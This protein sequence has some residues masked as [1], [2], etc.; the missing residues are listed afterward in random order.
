MTTDRAY[1]L[2]CFDLELCLK[3]W[4]SKQI[5]RYKL[6]EAAYRRAVEIRDTYFPDKQQNNTNEQH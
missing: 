1:E 2:A 4:D 6:A 3:I 5:E